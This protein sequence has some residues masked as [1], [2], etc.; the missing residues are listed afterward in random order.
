MEL[1]IF[2]TL[3]LAAP[4]LALVAWIGLVIDRKRRSVEVYYICNQNAGR[5]QLAAAY[6][7]RKYGSKVR[8]RSAGANP[9]TRVHP[10]VLEVLDADGLRGWT[11]T[12]AKIDYT[13]IDGGVPV[14]LCEDEEA[15]E[16]LSRL[17]PN[18]EDW[19]DTPDPSGETVATVSDIY[20]GLQA[21][22]DEL[23][24]DLIGPESVR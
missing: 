13:S 20:K 18:V 4:L 23:M 1:L 8:V 9:G 5:S 17:A 11:T 7:A 14:L 19:Q 3:M 16:T 24:R 12:P 2:L 6:T 22:I 10:N 21:R 15:F